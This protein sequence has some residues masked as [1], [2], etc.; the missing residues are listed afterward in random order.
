MKKYT[1]I[2]KTL[3]WEEVPES[4]DEGL[5]LQPEEAAAIDTALGK[6]VEDKTE[7]VNK[8][9]GELATA[10]QSLKDK[11]TELTTAT[12]RITAL[13]A[14][15]KNLVDKAVVPVQRWQQLKTKK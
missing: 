3:G 5:F 9:T 12:D 14:E 6:E 4:T 15:N 11:E 1:N 2:A 10:N 7:E 8:L 13:E